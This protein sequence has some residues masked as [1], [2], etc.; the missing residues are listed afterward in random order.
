MSVSVSPLAE[1][2]EPIMQCAIICKELGLTRFQRRLIYLMKNIDLYCPKKFH[3][4]Q[5][6]VAMCFD[7]LGIFSDVLFNFLACYDC[8]NQTSITSDRNKSIWILQI[9]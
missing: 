4:N 1:G 7:D 3:N 5:V 8:P 2:L 6:M 9:V